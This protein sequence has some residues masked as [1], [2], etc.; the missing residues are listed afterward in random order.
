MKSAQVMYDK[1]PIQS[2]VAEVYEPYFH[3]KNPE[4]CWHKIVQEEELEGME[5]PLK[6]RKK[7]CL[8]INSQSQV[9][10]SSES[11]LIILNGPNHTLEGSL[12]K[13]L[14]VKSNTLPPLILLKAL[15]FTEHK[16]LSDKLTSWM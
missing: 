8:F 16:L 15:A 13:G 9:S 10:N 1:K 3:N 5:E 4:T 7:V 2:W 14:L 11:S 12:F 6:G